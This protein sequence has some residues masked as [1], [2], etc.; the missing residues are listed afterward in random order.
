MNDERS[1]KTP[2]KSVTARNL[3]QGKWGNGVVLKGTEVHEFLGTRISV[4]RTCVSTVREKR[5]CVSKCKNGYSFKRAKLDKR[6]V[7]CSSSEHL[8][9]RSNQWARAE[10]S[11]LTL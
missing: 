9:E 5:E 7:K 8:V 3:V 1:K 4:P 11:E 2:K 6:L 10:R